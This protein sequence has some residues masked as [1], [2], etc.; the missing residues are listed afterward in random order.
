MAVTLIEGFDLYNGVGDNIGFK[1]KWL[2]SSEAGHSLV[3]GRFGGQA[4]RVQAIS[5]NDRRF[6]RS[7]GTSTATVALG[8]AF[9][10]SVFP[11]SQA[12]ALVHLQNGTGFMVG[13][14]ISTT[15]QI[16]IGR[17]TAYNTST[18]LGTSAAGV[19]LSN[20]WQYI[21]LEVVIH[22]TTGSV[23]VYVDNVLVLALTNVD[24]RNGT[25]TTVDRVGIG[26]MG[27]AAAGTA[28]Y[29]DMYATDTGIRLGERRVETI[30]AVGDSAFKNFTRNSGSANYETVDDTVVNISDY[31]IASNVGDLDLYD[32]LN[33]TVDPTTIDAVQVST[34]AR[35]SDA[36]AR[37]FAVVVRESGVELQS[38]DFVLP[39]DT[40]KFEHI[41]ATKPSGGAWNGTA[42]NNLLAGPKVT[43]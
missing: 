2:P 33:L 6:H 7:L 35:K 28:D 36:G 11:T 3:A 8:F 31:V 34:F 22:D 19:I 37:S 16:V 18:V 13:M 21:E 39:A 23:N 17:Y 26:C 20:T 40:T 29:D 41:F 43:V 4:L 32:F 5:G 12:N 10:Y 38:V 9:R 1:T 24:T 30:R 14:T 25:P 15:G 27:V 42:I